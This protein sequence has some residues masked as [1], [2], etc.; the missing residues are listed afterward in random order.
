MKKFFLVLLILLIISIL[1]LLGYSGYNAWKLGCTYYAER[2]AYSNLSDEYTVKNESTDLQPESTDTP[3][4][5]QN[6]GQFDPIIIE[7]SEKCPI[8]VDFDRLLNINNECVGWIYSFDENSFINYPVMRANNNY[9]YLDKLYDKSNARAGSIFMDYQ[10]KADFSSYNTIL[11]G[12]CMNDK[13]MFGTLKQYMKQDYYDAYPHLYLLTPTQN[14]KLVVIG[15]F[16]TE[17]VNKEDYRI[18][19]TPKEVQAHAERVVKK[20]VIKTNVDPSSVD[21]FVTLSTCSRE[22]GGARW[23]VVCWPVPIK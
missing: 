4:D 12:H 16:T 1:A 6:I 14:Y 21:K 2:K 18:F 23:I 19:N 10:C 3:H 22:F 11:Y 5:K 17:D 13:S 7:E 9:Y 8:T 15:A 20:S